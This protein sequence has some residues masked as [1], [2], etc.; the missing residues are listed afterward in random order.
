MGDVLLVRHAETAW[1]KA[2]RHTGRTDVP[3]TDEG[4]AI[5][6]RLAGRLAERE[7]ALVLTSPLGRAA[8]T[9][10][11]AGLRAEEEPGL[12]EW[13]YGAYEGRTT[14]D[15]REERPGWYLF[16]DGAPGGE[17]ADDVGRRA[18]GVI[19]R[20]LGTLGEDGSGGDAC[21]VGHSHMLR[22]LAARWLEQ[23]AALGG[24]LWLRTGSVSV[25][26]WEREVRVLRAWN[27]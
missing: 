8:E 27:G 11:L 1:S 15:I 22:V 20:V 21:L 13:D 18:D 23:P 2:R 4:R 24:R 6:A 10:R 7:F 14:V 26:G 25:L 17:T 9:A 19:E 5:A 3:L 16:D 12:L